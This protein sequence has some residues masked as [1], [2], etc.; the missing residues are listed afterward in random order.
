ME[1]TPQAA[2]KPYNRR[3]VLAPAF[4]ESPPSPAPS[5]VD[6]DPDSVSAPELLGQLDRRTTFGRRA[7]S[8][9]PELS[10]PQDIMAGVVDGDQRPITPKPLSFK[11]KARGSSFSIFEDK[12]KTPDKNLK[13]RTGS[14]E[15]PVLTLTKPNSQGEIKLN[16]K[17]TKPSPTTRASPDS[18]SSS[19]PLGVPLQPSTPNRNPRASL[20]AD[21]EDR[22]L[23][24]IDGETPS[25]RKLRGNSA[26]YAEIR[27]LQK[28]VDA[29]N[30]E[31]L[32]TRRELE[33]A[34][35][36]ASASTL[37]Q[38]VRE[39]QEQLKVWRNRAEWAEKQLRERGMNSRQVSGAAAGGT[40]SRGHAHRYSMS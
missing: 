2:I 36:M 33:L 13:A 24:D 37:S 7:I 39:T 6:G 18:D 3:P 34:K 4:E 40:F 1:M 8:P 19:R 38:L 15:S 29:K 10:P 25:P 20:E 22:F 28:L 14:I 27:R 16:I 17:G 32:Q 30:E 5:T 35:S 12:D 9:V 21:F 26:L 23:F 11:K 31:A